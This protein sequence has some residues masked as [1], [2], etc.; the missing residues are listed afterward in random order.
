MGNPVLA[1]AIFCQYQLPS[2][3]FQRYSG[4]PSTDTQNESAP[5]DINPQARP[6]KMYWPGVVMLKLNV[7]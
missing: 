1:S 5:V 3:V 4:P 7:T 6:Q 2:I